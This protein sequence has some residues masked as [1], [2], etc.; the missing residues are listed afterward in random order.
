MREVQNNEDENTLWTDRRTIEIKHNHFSIFCAI[1]ASSGTYQRWICTFDSPYHGS[2]ASW[3][4]SDK[5]SNE[6]SRFKIP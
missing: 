2:I 5:I 3:L 4:E 6:I 1:A